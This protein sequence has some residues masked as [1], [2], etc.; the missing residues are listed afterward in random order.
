MPKP[1]NVY[2]YGTVTIKDEAGVP[3]DNFDW[4]NGEQNLEQMLFTWVLNN[5]QHRGPIT[6]QLNIAEL[7]TVV[8]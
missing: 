3:L 4:S 1:L 2:I 6:L 7:H 8:E 5:P